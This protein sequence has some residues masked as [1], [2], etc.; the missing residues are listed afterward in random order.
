MHGNPR[1][2]SLR[3]LCVLSPSQLPPWVPLQD[4]KGVRFLVRYWLAVCMSH[5]SFC[6]YQVT[7]EV[8]AMLR[9]SVVREAEAVAVRGV[10]T[11]LTWC[12]G[13]HTSANKH[14][15][16][17]WSAPTQSMQLVQALRSIYNARRYVANLE[18]KLTEELAAVKGLA[19]DIL[20][21]ALA[22]QM[23]G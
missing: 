15:Y 13:H 18:A 7:P 12:V 16:I 2:H 23:Y 3:P 19:D 1:Q 5:G 10:E 20:D 6:C 21:P 22:R 8:H 4:L 14:M 9:N 11:R 17:V